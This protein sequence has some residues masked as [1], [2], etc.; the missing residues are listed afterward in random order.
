MRFDPYE[1]HY[2]MVLQHEST[3]RIKSLSRNMSVVLCDSGKCRGGTD[4]AANWEDPKC[5][6]GLPGT[7]E[8]HRES[9]HR[10]LTFIKMAAVCRSS[11]KAS[12][13]RP[14]WVILSGQTAIARSTAAK[15]YAPCS[16]ATV[17]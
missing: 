12:V 11:G 10:K 13:K 8:G 9:C 5:Q 4:S 17:R 3:V 7:R 16:F 2:K 15:A 1:V 6:D 14:K